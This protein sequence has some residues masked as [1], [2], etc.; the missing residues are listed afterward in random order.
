[1]ITFIR[2]LLNLFLLIYT[3]LASPLSLHRSRFTALLS[4]HLCCHQK[5]SV[6]PVCHL[7]FQKVLLSFQN[8]TKSQVARALHFIFWVY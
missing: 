2:I 4:L 3:T 1:V 6:F 5:V 8:V 7:S